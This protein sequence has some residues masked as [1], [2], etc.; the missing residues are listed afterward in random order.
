MP[1]L[2]LR[3]RATL[4]SMVSFGVLPG[5]DPSGDLLGTAEMAEALG[6]DSAWVGDHLL[7][8]V[9]SP[10]PGV[11]LGALAARTTRLRLGTAVMLA[12]LRS[13]L[14]VAK[15]AATLDHLSEGRFVLGVGL[16]GENPAEFAAAGVPLR[17]RSGRLDETLTLCRAL[18]AGEPVNH[19]GRYFPMENV[20]F[21]LPPRTPG[22]PPVWVG[23]RA[24]GALRRAGRLGDG[25][26]AF[27]VTPERFAAGWATV[28][29][30][31]T[32]AGRDPDALTPA[33]QLWCNLAE[34]DEAAREELAPRI[35]RFYRTPFARF[36]P[37]TICGDAETWRERI[38]AFAAAGVR[39]FNLI[40]EGGEPLAQ[41]ARFASELMPELQA[42][43][44]REPL[45]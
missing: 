26:L 8:H 15:M 31:A 7:W 35:E 18:W 2:L 40:F 20:R 33:L 44:R 41:M 38:A 10:D 14:V 45:S 37:Y 42:L 30:H 9:A 29:R 6:F 16:G 23:G 13:P 11:L 34:S 12:A 22:G 36:E 5:H 43:G 17:E 1:F 39:H 25:W 24:P 4:C 3:T 19:S 28:R 32:E 27:V 21:D